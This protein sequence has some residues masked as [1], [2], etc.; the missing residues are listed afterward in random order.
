MYSSEPPLVESSYMKK[1]EH[2]CFF[3]C[4]FFPAKLQKSPEEAFRLLDMS[5]SKKEVFVGKEK[6]N[7]LHNLLYY[8]IKLL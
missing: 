5:Q 3:F 2:G 4:L 8:D 7:S 1:S 6:P